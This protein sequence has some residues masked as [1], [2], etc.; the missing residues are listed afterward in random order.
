MAGTVAYVSVNGLLKVFAGAGV[1]GLILFS[2]IEAAKIVATSVIHTYGKKIGW[3]YNFL[4]SI[5]IVIAMAITSMGI[6]G[7]LSSSYKETFSKFEN[8]E[9]QIKLLEKKRDGY[10]AQ[11][12]NTI[13]EKNTIN[14][15]ASDLSR[16][17]SNNTVQY[18]DKNT[19]QIITT[20][21]SSNRKALEN[22]LNKT[23]ERQNQLIF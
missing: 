4:L 12:D 5:F 20:T 9:A 15:T 7:F 13:N 6:Y 19:G 1:V 17:L 23:N 2:T 10:Q 14:Q 21:S 11:L 8:T 22:Q 3:F 18:K 16:G